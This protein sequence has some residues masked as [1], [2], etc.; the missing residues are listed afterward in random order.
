ME[1]R[2]SEELNNIFYVQ[3]KM[4][5]FINVSIL[6]MI[7]ELNKRTKQ[8]LSNCQTKNWIKNV[9][10]SQMVAIVTNSLLQEDSF[11][12]GVV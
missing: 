3:H 5:S 10:T 6:K 12:S 11:V 2:H 8:K 7:I 1:Q 4:H 9:Q